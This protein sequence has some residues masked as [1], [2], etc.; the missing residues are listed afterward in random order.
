MASNHKRAGT[1][2]GEKMR[3]RKLP[4]AVATLLILTPMVGQ[5]QDAETL[6]HERTCIACHGPEGRTPVMDE[7]PRLAGQP[8]NYLLL[9]MRAIKSGERLNAHSL[10]M[11]NVM[12]MVDEAEM[13]TLA[14]W[15]SKLPQ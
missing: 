15:L 11:K 12:H 14:Q 1:E 6:Y 4:M 3:V 9:Q 5:A 13:A 10:A 8:A 7:Y 2:T